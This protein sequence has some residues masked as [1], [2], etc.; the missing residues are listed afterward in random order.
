MTTYFEYSEYD[1]NKLIYSFVTLTP[2]QI[3]EKRE[4]AAAAEK[5]AAAKKAATQKPT[6]EFKKQ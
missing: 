4:R 5:E 1:R 2:E 6:T 3:S